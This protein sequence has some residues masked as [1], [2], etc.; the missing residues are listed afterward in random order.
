MAPPFV[1]NGAFIFTLFRMLDLHQRDIKAIPKEHVGLTKNNVSKGEC[2]MVYYLCGTLGKT[3]RAYNTHVDGQL[4]L[5]HLEPDAFDS[6]INKAYFFNGCYYHGHGADCLIKG[7]TKVARRGSDEDFNARLTLFKA[8]YPHCEVEVLWECNWNQQLTQDDKKAFFNT[9]PWAFDPP[10]HRLIARDAVRGGHSETYNFIW[11]KNLNPGEEFI[12]LDIISQYPDIAMSESLPVGDF[13]VLIGDG[14]K[15][16]SVSH[17]LS[18]NGREI[19]GL[20]FLLIEAPRDTKYPF[21]LPRTKD[22]RSVATLC[23]KCAEDQV[24]TP[25]NHNDIDRFIR[26]TYTSV[27]IN[28]AISLGYKIHHI[29]EIWHWARQE[30]ISKKFMQ[31]LMQ[32]KVMYSGLPENCNTEQKSNNYC[33]AVNRTL[34][35]EGDAKLTLAKNL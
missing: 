2:Q 1:S 18:V 6:D 7:K 15:N 8:A 30:N 10:L 21:L 22:K 3:L 4:K 19:Y 14:L 5:K 23:V 9:R 11:S 31:L 33:D 16:L 28:Y 17:P 35:L 32:K 13:E 25:C 34:Q 26:G 29:F 24:I 12:Y 20:I 27:E